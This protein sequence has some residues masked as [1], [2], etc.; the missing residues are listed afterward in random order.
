MNNSC[1]GLPFSFGVANKVSF[2]LILIH[3]FW[4]VLQNILVN[5]SP[6]CCVMEKWKY[7]FNSFRAKFLSLVKLIVNL[8]CL[9]FKPLN[10]KSDEIMRKL[11]Y[12]FLLL[13][14]S[15]LNNLN[16]QS[17]SSFLTIDTIKNPDT[18]EMIGKNAV[19]AD[20]NAEKTI[21]SSASFSNLSEIGCYTDKLVLKDGWNWISF[22]RMERTGNDY[23]PTIPVLERINY[24]PEL[25]MTIINQGSLE[26]NFEQD[27]KS[28]V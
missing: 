16:P 25:D 27:R 23:A 1:F 2:F 14:I 11:K 4:I 3:L 28:V 15:L 20:R 18:I 12:F 22:P 19:S 7:Y 8:D 10:I 5:R 6:S 9:F 13:F 21:N 17:L 26:L 24:F